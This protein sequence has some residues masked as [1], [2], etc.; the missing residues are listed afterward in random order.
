MSRPGKIETISLEIGAPSS[1]HT[2]TA[3]V[4]LSLFDLSTP[5]W[6]DPSISCTDL[7]EYIG[8]QTGARSTEAPT[9]ATFAIVGGNTGSINWNSFATGTPDYPDRSTTII[10]QVDD[11]QEDGP[12]RLSGPGIETEHRLT[13][14]GID[15][16]FWQSRQHNTALYPLGTDA[17]LVAQNKIACLPRTTRVEV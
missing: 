15:A 3:A 9:I 4:V 5:F 6:V 8:F 12:V 16:G 17:I 11:L 1:L 14:T 7:V 10:I 2:A 13:V